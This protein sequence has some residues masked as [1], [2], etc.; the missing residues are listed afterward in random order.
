[1]NE[2]DEKVRT[3]QQER[4][5]K[6]KEAILQAA[7]RLFSENGFHQTNTKQIAAAAGVSTGSFYSYFVDKRAVFMDSLKIYNDSLLSRVDA[8]LAEIDFANMEKQTAIR[9]MVDSLIQS[10][11]VY[12]E[13]HKELAVMYH[14][15]NEIQMIMDEQFELGR[16]KTLG[17]LQQGQAELKVDDLEAASCVVFE[18]LNSIVDMI[19]FSP[20][21]VSTDRLKNEL[22][23]MITDYLYK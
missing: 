5:I 3:P 13:F 7:M 10:H 8:S 9:H 21:S 6:T 23:R 1:M 14:S 12:A 15:D 18:A 11:Q 22:I 19:V 17:Y 20:K 2:A 16:R 4:S